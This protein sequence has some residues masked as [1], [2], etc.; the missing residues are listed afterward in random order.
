MP[1][2]IPA[3]S[4]LTKTMLKALSTHAGVPERYRPVV[5]EGTYDDFKACVFRVCSYQ[6][7]E[8]MLEDMKEDC[9]RVGFGCLWQH[10]QWVYE[11]ESRLATRTELTL[12]GIPISDV[13][14]GRFLKGLASTYGFEYANLTVNRNREVA[15]R[16]GGFYSCDRREKQEIQL[17]IMWPCWM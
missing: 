12:T 8:V 1:S 14:V 17:E 3:G 2:G 13:D 15:V 16:S 11:D 4:E 10:R 7:C 9:L 5:E 6:I